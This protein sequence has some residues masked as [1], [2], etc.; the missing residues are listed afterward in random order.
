MD[1]GFCRNGAFL[2]EGAQCGGPLGRLLYWGHWKI[3]K[4]RLRIWAS[5][6]IGA[7]LSLSGTRNRRGSRIP[8][9]LNDERRGALVTGHLS[10]WGLHEVG[11][12][13]GF[14]YWR[15]RKIC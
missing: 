1:E 7:P 11:L 13:G 2:S 14:L 8:G 12:E 3:C 4:E 10:L 6:S 9:T 5:L 15:P